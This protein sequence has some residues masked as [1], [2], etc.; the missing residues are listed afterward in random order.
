MEGADNSVLDASHHDGCTPQCGKLLWCRVACSCFNRTVA[1]FLNRIFSRPTSGVSLRGDEN[2]VYYNRMSDGEGACIRIGGDDY[3][4][5][6]YGRDNVV[7]TL[8]YPSYV[9]Y[10]AQIIS[11]FQFSSIWQVV[12]ERHFSLLCALSS[13]LH[14]LD[15][16]SRFSSLVFRH[17]SKFCRTPR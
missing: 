3:D 9:S 12:A 4:S 1:A 14:W 10:G 15:F 16:D 5:I 2:V 7:C 13:R 6:D 11:A 8:I 17:G